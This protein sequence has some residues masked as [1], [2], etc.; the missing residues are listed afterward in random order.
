[1]VL[2]VTLPL[3]NPSLKGADKNS[4]MIAITITKENTTSK[5]PQLGRVFPN[6][7][8]P[9]LGIGKYKTV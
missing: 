2:F 4:Y 9:F 5:M 8:Y 3:S 7:T 1:M 6:P